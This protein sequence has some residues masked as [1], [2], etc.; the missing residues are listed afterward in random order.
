[1]QLSKL[2][3]MYSLA[4]KEHYGLLRKQF[5]LAGIIDRAFITSTVL[6]SAGVVTGWRGRGKKSAPLYLFAPRE[7]PK[8]QAD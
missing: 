6:P 5:L 2:W 8:A 7:T 3:D 4:R 1:M